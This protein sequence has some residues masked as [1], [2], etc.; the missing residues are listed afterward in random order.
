VRT[1][2]DEAR[3]REWRD[4]AGDL[5]GRDPPDHDREWADLEATTEDY[6]ALDQLLPADAT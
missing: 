5:D 4:G 3:L 1:A 6:D 2:L